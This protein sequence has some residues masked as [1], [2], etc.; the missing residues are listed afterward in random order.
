MI[1]IRGTRRKEVYPKPLLPSIFHP[2]KHTF[3]LIV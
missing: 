2:P 1:E 3:F